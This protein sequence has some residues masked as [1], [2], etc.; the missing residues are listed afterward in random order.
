MFNRIPDSLIINGF[1]FTLKAVTDEFEKGCDGALGVNMRSNTIY[2]EQTDSNDYMVSQILGFVLDATFQ[3]NG[4]TTE[5]SKKIN[6]DKNQ[7]LRIM[8]RNFF[9][10]LRDNPID[11]RMVALNTPL[12]EESIVEPIVVP[13]EKT[14]DAQVREIMEKV[15]SGEP[16]S[17]EPS[18]EATASQAMEEI[19]GFEYD[20]TTGEI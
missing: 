16:P 19:G 12:L 20:E 8:E 14:L 4:I 6:I 9:C 3:M 13:R 18:L 11:W 7:L 15:V 17:D 10:F 1:K 5:R 2:Y